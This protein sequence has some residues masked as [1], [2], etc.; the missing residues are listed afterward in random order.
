[1]TPT[2]PAIPATTH[3]GPDRRASR[4]A[5]A[6]RETRRAVSRGRLTCPASPTRTQ[7]TPAGTGVPGAASVSTASVGSAHVVTPARTAAS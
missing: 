4:D 3:V 6:M 7:G 2:P 1:M 5:S